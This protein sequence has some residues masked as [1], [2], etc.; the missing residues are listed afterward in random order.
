MK[1]N[2]KYVLYHLF[3]HKKQDKPILSIT[4]TYVKT[5]IVVRENQT[6][7]RAHVQI[8][9]VEDELSYQADESPTVL[10]VLTIELVQGLAET[11]I[12]EVLDDDP[13]E[14]VDDDTNEDIDNS[15][16]Q[17]PY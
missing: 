6:K 12:L 7:P 8:D 3:F 17:H 10:P 1:L 4:Q 11:K 14:P 5:F 15:D 2:G 13:I 16:E 9:N